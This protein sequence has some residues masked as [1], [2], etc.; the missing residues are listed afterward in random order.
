[1]PASPYRDDWPHLTLLRGITAPEQVTDQALLAQMT[2]VVNL[3]EFSLTGSVAIIANKHNEFYS[4]TG[5]LL[6]APSEELLAYRNRCISALQQRGFRVDPHELVDYSP[7]LTIRLGVPLTG[8]LLARAEK[9][10]LGQTVKF[11]GWMLLRLVADSSQGRQM[12]EV[13]FSQ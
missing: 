4:D 8:D 2:R 11:S 1:L 9:D 7:H 12:H 6:F 13:I 3:K 5:V 10:F